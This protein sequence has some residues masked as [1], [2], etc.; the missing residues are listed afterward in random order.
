MVKGTAKNCSGGC[1]LHWTV[2]PAGQ[3][4]H[5]LQAAAFYLAVV[6]VLWCIPACIYHR[7]S[8]TGQAVV[9]TLVDTATDG[10]Q[11]LA[12]PKFEH[13]FPSRSSIKNSSLLSSNQDRQSEHL[14]EAVPTTQIPPPPIID[15]TTE[16][17]NDT[18]ILGNE[19][20][21]VLLKKITAE[22]PPEVV[23]IVR[24]E[25]KINSDEL[26]LRVEEEEEEAGQAQVPEE[27]SSKVDD[28]FTTAPELNDTAARARLVGDSRDETAAVIL[29]GLVTSG[30]TEPHE[31]IPSF[32]EWA[33]KRLEE[34]EKK[35]THPNAS[36]QTPGGP[37]RGVSGMKIR[38]KNYASPDCGAKIV[39][40]NPEANSA[41]NVL[42]STRDEYMLNACTSR[43]WFVVELCEA[44]Q[45]KKIELANFELFSSSPKDFSVYVSDRFPTK[46]WSLVGQFTAKDVK[47]IQSF[48][49]HPHFFGKFIKVELQSHYGSEHFCPVSL[50]RAYGTSEFE[51]LETETEN[52][53]LEEKH[54]DEDDDEDSD[55]EESLDS[56]G[57][58]SPSN[59]FGSARDAVL[60]VVK[61]AAEILV[62]SSGLTGNNITQI[63]QSIDHGNI[64]DNS[65]TS[66]TTP[67]Y[68]IL[69]GNCT[70]QKF[71]SVFQ[72]VS[73]KNRQL[74][75]LLRID[76]VNRTLRQGKLCGLH[77]VEIES[78]WWRRE[79]AETKH[80]DT[81]HF[82]LAENFQTTFLT[83]F[84]KPE[85][86]IALCN[87][88][89]TKERKVVM[90]TS[91][92]I[93]VNKSKDAA[94]DILSTKNTDHSAEITFNGQT[95]S[96]VDPCTLDSS[97]SA[98]KS[99]ASSKEVRQ[100]SLIQDVNKESENIS[101]ATIETSSSF[102][103]SLASQI[104][105]TKTL[106]KEDLKKESSVPILEPSKEFTDET[107]QPQVLT[108]APPPS[109]PTPTL[110]MV[111]ELPV[112]GTPVETTL[113]LSSVPPINIDSQETSQETVV[114]DTESAETVAQ[115]KMNK[116]E[117][118]EQDGRQMKDLG[119]QEA[120]LSSQ[121][122]L[123]LDSLLSDLK[124]LEVDTANMQNGASSS[125]P[126][127][128]PT[129]NIVPQKESVF[130]RLS[131]RIKILERNMSLSGQYLEELSR[132]YKKQ[133]EEMQRSLERAVAAM[134]EESRKSEERDVKRA[135]EIA[136]LREE[137]MILSKSVET[138]LYDRDSWR[139]RISAIIQHTLLICL[140]IIIITLIL[141]YCR[142]REDFE[143]EKLESDARKDTIR[144]KSAE[145]FSSHAAAKKTKR[146]RPSEIASHIS[147]TYHEL[148]IDDRPYETKK[149]RKKK[150]KKE[151]IAA[152][153]KAAVNTDA[154]Q[155]VVRYKSVLNVIPGGTTLPS[156]RSSSI[157]SP[158]SKELQDSV[159]K[160][161]ESAPDT[162]VGWF[163]DQVERI[164]RITQPA[165]E[166]R[167]KAESRASSE[168]GRQVNELGKPNTSLVI[169]NRPVE[170]S[171]PCL[172]ATVERKIESSRNGSFR[173]GS[174]LK[175]ARLSSPSFMKTALGTRSKRKFSTNS[176][177]S[178][179]GEWSQDSEQSND[180]SSQ[181]S[182]T[183]FKMLSQIIGDRANGSTANGLI[184]ESDES[185]SS[186]A[187]PTSI[188]KE[189]R[190]TGL[191]KM[192]R[193]FF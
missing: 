148:M 45:A 128:Q 149:E 93:S 61:K 15:E 92:E 29:N 66:C 167:A 133:V 124:D 178:E 10:L 59:L 143:E 185:R 182:P 116:S 85:Y 103:E 107:L 155:E 188:K 140:E 138:L 154:R 53:T 130:L 4:R 38:N 46:D 68:T 86:I 142:R 71:A 97:L 127:T 5:L 19:E 119:E 26:E 18:D 99:A 11:N 74:D 166:D 51:V 82:N 34:A 176:T 21:V 186:S 144:R 118:G 12:E 151:A 122:H 159:G 1:P 6:A 64:L 172:N 24:A 42:V 183:D 91:Y 77:G 58:D 100:H 49:L 40:A 57:G 105:P 132:R 104:K 147:G 98:C 162:V 152:G 115:V 165:P 121:D 123:S 158:N 69:C 95:S 35:K 81:T 191:K 169:V 75:G 170:R 25:Q 13:E 50:F 146:R 63:Q 102:P 72:L 108:T 192:V 111:E 106:S 79:E 141:S 60:N 80:D 164:E 90:N 28:T 171:G 134:G 150:R 145:N 160:R 3:H 181:S 33:Q 52:E 17:P 8:E 113:S 27:L 76:L 139:S 136:V 180:R 156:R 179:K 43:V 22:E 129:A 87:V 137:I 70:D 168:F 109:S 193:K 110:K 56:E 84:F 101:I 55:E 39:A 89:A 48:T 9:L 174:I 88:L 173:A 135:E 175:G 190:G 187:T 37:G 14:K 184:E 153:I 131:N 20:D 54:T 117:N 114:P 36:V 32:S 112:S 78:F 16:R 94:S 62:K 7:I 157:D 161:P 96:T 47:D 23:V 189:K 126:T 125:S 2:N 163:D 30:P 44:I 83:S 120:R 177:N 31:D 41:K 73:C 65:Y 67:R